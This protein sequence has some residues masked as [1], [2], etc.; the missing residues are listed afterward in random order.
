MNWWT[1]IKP[2]VSLPAEPDSLLKHGVY[3]VIYFGK[4]SSDKISPEYIFVTGT[5][6]VGIKYKSSST[7]LYISS[8][9]FGNWPVPVIVAALAINGGRISS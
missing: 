2:L 6:A 8:L 3:A 9:N 4:S 7:H 5:S 1:L